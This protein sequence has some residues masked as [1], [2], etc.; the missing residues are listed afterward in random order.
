[1]IRE[2]TKGAAVIEK[3][4][5][6]R[7]RGIGVVVPGLLD[8]NRETVRV[9]ANLTFLNGRNLRTPIAEATELP[10]VL[11]PSMEAHHLAESSFG[12][13]TGVPDFFVMN[14]AGGI[15]ISVCMNRELLRGRLGT[16]IE[17]GHITVD[18]QGPLCG[19][20]NHGCLEHYGSDETILR[21]GRR[22]LRRD[23]NIQ[24]IVKLCHTG[25]L[26]LTREL[27]A[28]TDSLALAVATGITLFSPTKVLLFGYF[29]FAAEGLFERLRAEVARRALRTRMADCEILMPQA[30]AHRSQQLGA[31]VAVVN[32]LAISAASGK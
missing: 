18:P 20:G 12:P 19:C 30:D 16:G 22:V 28:A 6:V 26:D 9:S 5:G 27:N 10:V 17:L 15:G 29:L 14:F 31:S 24:E 32:E 1:L 4:L 7:L 8:A 2:I 3:R 13:L 23:A 11:V 21:A 25:R